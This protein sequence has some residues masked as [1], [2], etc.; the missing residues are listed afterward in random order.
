MSKGQTA[1][2][3]I[4]KQVQIV[5]TTLASPMILSDFRIIIACI[6]P[7]WYG[8]NART[9]RLNLYLTGDLQMKNTPR[10]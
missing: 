5:M 10:I 1:H 8:Q 4:H 9:F 3:Q 2:T 7:I 6:S